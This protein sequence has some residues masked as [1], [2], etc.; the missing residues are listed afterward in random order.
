MSGRFVRA[1]AFRH[2]F[3]EDPKEDQ[4]FS[5]IRQQAS[6]DGNGCAMNT[7][8]FGVPVTGGGGPVKI[9]SLDR[10][11][12]NKDSGKLGVHKAKVLDIAFHPFIDEM[13]ATASEDCTAQVTK[14]PEGGITS[15][16]ISQSD[17]KLEGHQ[18]KVSLLRWHPTSMNILA[19][20]SFDQT[21][22]V[23]D[24]EA[25]SEVFNYAGHTD[26]CMSLDWN[27]NGSL[28]CSTSKDKKVR[29]F[30]PRAPEG[31][32]ESE[33]GPAGSKKSTAMWMDNH[34]KIGVVGFSKKAVRQ[35]MLFDPRAFDK[36]IVS[37][38]LDSSAGVVMCHYDPD[39]SILYMAGKG[40][41]SIKYFEVT[42][43]APHV[44]Y[45]SEYRGS[46]SQKGV[47][48]MPKRGVDTTKCEVQRCLRLMRDKL[49]PVSLRVPRKSEMFQEDLYPDTYAGIS[50]QTAADYV[51]GK[52]S[53]PK[54]QSMDPSKSTDRKKVEIKVKRSAAELERLLA[55]AEARIK[56]LEAQ[57]AAK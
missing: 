24:I 33:G 13:V 44:H 28:C 51:A 35:Y 29:I 23:W 39:N 25:Q 1:S 57:L 36:P 12:R 7:K 21:V 45:L 19:T 38:D 40:D 4:C 22:K 52:N 5:D 50:T 14:F 37:A 3:G 27:S 9:G 42:D 32:L 41:A 31:T 47:A 20:A 53:D 56:E 8:Y 55:A 11:G 6:G 26:V 54:T 10:P 46:E 49:A 18:K 34:Q 17:V 43:D 30:D 48:F 15:E 16:N 2:V